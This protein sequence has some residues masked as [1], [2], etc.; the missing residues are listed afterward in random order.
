ME[1]IYL[2]VA[3]ASVSILLILIY[4]IMGAFFITLSMLGKVLKATGVLGG[5]LDDVADD[6]AEVVRTAL[7]TLQSAAGLFR[8]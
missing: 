7:K 4:P 6:A 5:A 3:F 8:E 1:R 2:Y